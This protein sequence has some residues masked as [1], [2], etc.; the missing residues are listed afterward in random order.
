MNQEARAD[1]FDT[2]II[3]KLVMKFILNDTI[4][5]RSQLLKYY[6]F[7]YFFAVLDELIINRS[8][9]KRIESRGKYEFLVKLSYI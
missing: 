8:I 4:F 3:I 2:T 6:V 7:E 9:P 5:R 1:L